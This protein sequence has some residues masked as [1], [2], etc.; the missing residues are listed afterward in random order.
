[1]LWHGG[2]PGGRLTPMAERRM[3]F[4]V[5]HED[6]LWIVHEV[7]TGQPMASFDTQDEAVRTGRHLADITQAELLVMNA[8]GTLRSRESGAL[9]ETA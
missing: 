3:R 8:D 6:G 1:M 7:G 9:L 4:M 2:L 5:V